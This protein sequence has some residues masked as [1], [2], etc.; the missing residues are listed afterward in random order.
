MRPELRF[1]SFASHPAHAAVHAAL[2]EFGEHPNR[3]IAERHR[4]FVTVS[5]EPGAGAL[6]FS[7]R[8]AESL[9]NHGEPGWTA[10]DQELVEKVSSE[11][12]I[13]RQIVA[14]LSE[15][16]HNWLEELFQGMS[17]DEMARHSDELW[18]YKRM[19]LTIRLLANA[20]RAIIV[21]RGGLFVTA[22][23]PGGIHLRLVAPLAQRIEHYAEVYHLTPRDAEKKVAELSQARAEFLNRYWPGRPMVP[24]MFTLTLN[25]ARM[26][27]DE[28]VNAVT[29]LVLSR[30]RGTPPPALTESV[31]S[32][33]QLT[34]A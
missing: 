25:S 21:G 9:A 19:A 20:G 31:R 18:V 23:M 3:D 16:R 22:G 7:H 26:S 34:H 28:M 12:K 32:V 15:R 13:S 10:W 30:L 1:S 17:Q 2:H 29:P 27:L 24:E 6:S 4:V 14:L 5:R 11:F 33:E 8:L